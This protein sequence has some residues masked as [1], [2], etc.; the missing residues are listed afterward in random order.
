MRGYEEVLEAELEEIMDPF[1]VKDIQ[2]DRGSTWIA[3]E[4]KRRD[5]VDIILSSPAVYSREGFLS[6]NIRNLGKQDNLD[7][8]KV[9][10]TE[11]G[12]RYLRNEKKA[13]K[14]EI[15][16]EAEKF[17]ELETN[18]KLKAISKIFSYIEEHQKVEFENYLDN[19]QY[20]WVE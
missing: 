13:E 19:D 3:N 12:L 7:G 20:R 4:L 16:E 11:Q 6:E 8:Y 9:I 5:E 15:W 14:K 17:L 18:G 10:A 2:V 1:M